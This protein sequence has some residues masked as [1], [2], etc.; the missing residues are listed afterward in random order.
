MR[1]PFLRTQDVHG[2]FVF[3]NIILKGITYLLFRLMNAGP[4]M[5]FFFPLGRTYYENS[6]SFLS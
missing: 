4:T 2:A 6:R 3:S 5:G 1:D